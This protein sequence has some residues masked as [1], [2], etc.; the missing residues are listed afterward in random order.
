VHAQHTGVALDALRRTLIAILLLTPAIGLAAIGVTWMVVRGQA[1]PVQPAWI[2][3][4]LI[5]VA[6]SAAAMKFAGPRHATYR[7]VGA[8]AIGAAMVLAGIVG[9]VDPITVGAERTGAFTAALAALRERE[10]GP[11]LFYRIMP[12]SE[13]VKFMVNVDDLL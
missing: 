10:P 11:I 5:F 7:P 2:P 9:I 8:A 1:M 12:D 3:T 6:L 13:D 4:I